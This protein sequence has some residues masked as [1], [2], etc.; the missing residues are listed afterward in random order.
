MNA[1]NLAAAL[2]K[3]GRRLLGGLLAALLLVPMPVL[4]SVTF[5][6][7]WSPTF[8]TSGSPTPPTPTFS[9][10]TTSNGSHG[11]QDVLDVG[12]GTYNGNPASKPSQESFETITLTRQINWSPSG[13]ENLNGVWT[14]DEF[15]N[16]AAQGADQV[17]VLNSK[18]NVVT[19]LIGNQ[20]Y[21]GSG[22]TPSEVKMS[23]HEFLP[24]SQL[25]AGTYTLQVT[26][27]LHTL[28]N[29]KLG[30]QWKSKSKSHE[31][32]FYAQ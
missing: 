32:D 10:S 4:A 26:V 3:G 28:V 18:G 9:D 17:N 20:M 25:P 12:M 16:S 14:L 30:G 23:D 7:S 5:S 2:L 31:F 6:G 21:M 29:N 24:P 13:P 19:H 11:Q 1:M 22:S 8:S 15:L 27:Q